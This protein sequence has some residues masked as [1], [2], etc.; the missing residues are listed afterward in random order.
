MATTFT[1]HEFYSRKVLKALPAQ[2]NFLGAFSTDVS[3][4]LL[5]PSKSVE[6]PL[7]EMDAAAAFNRT[8]NNFARTAMTPKT[9]TVTFGDPIIAG[10]SVTADQA[11]KIDKRWW[12]G[13]AELNATA[14]AASASTAVT[15]LITKTNFAKAVTGV[16]TA[17]NFAK[18]G[19]AKIAAAVESSTNK[20]RV[21]FSTLCLSGEYFYNLL[22][23]LDANVYGGTEAIRNGVI[24]GLFGFGKVMLMH[25]LDIPGFVCE[26]SAI[27]FA[28]RGFRPADDTPY[29]AVREIKDPES[30]LMLTLVEYG[31]GPTGDLSESVTTRIGA[32]VGD[33]G[34][35]VRLVAGNTDG[36]GS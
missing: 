8:S 7:V 4:E 1:G 28:G 20:L 9:A 36:S 16:G 17:A 11:S 21:K 34:A 35:L 19:V 31:D 27:A 22:A 13:K 32:A 23:G 6:V 18:S 14:V 30:G 33:A 12:E 5:G 29:R 3:G 10:F 25:G 15:S 2:L 26:P 24:P